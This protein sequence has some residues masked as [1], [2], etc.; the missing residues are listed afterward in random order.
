[1]AQV[2]HTEIRVFDHARN[3]K[4]LAV[5][6]SVVSSCCNDYENIGKPKSQALKQIDGLEHTVGFLL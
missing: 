5:V 1:M 6:Y 3:G 2:P 4:Y